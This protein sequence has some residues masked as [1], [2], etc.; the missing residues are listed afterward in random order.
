MFCAK[1]NTTSEHLPLEDEHTYPSDMKREESFLR[2]MMESM[3]EFERRSV[4][5]YGSR[6][7]IFVDGKTAS[8]LVPEI[9]NALVDGE[10]G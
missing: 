6:V 10:R 8:E 9:V 3:K 4:L 2:E 1:R 5:R 7:V